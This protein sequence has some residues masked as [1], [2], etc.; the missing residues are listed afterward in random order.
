MKVMRSLR[1]KK[2]I[3]AEANSLLNNL[4][5]TARKYNIQPCLF[6][7]WKRDI[8][9][10]KAAVTPE[11]AAKMTMDDINK[12]LRKKRYIGA[13]LETFLPLNMSI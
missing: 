8:I 7:C 11:E 12:Y 2:A 6:R 10:R 3:V 1:E 13:H 4:K 5:A 9:E